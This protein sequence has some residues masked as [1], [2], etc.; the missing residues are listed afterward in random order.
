MNGVHF[1]KLNPLTS[2]VGKLNGVHF[3]ELNPAHFGGRQTERRSFCQA[4]RKL[5]GAHFA[6]LDAV[7]S[8]GR[9]N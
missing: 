4:L 1:A 7:R 5:D 3:A 9:T 8:V 6:T 2:E